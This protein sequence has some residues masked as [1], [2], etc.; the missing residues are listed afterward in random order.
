MRCWESTA[1]IWNCNSWAKLE[2]G[3]AAWERGKASQILFLIFSQLMKECWDLHTLDTPHAFGY[4]THLWVSLLPN[5]TVPSQETLMPPCCCSW[6]SPGW[7]RS[8]VQIPKTLPGS[9]TQPQPWAAHGT[10]TQSHEQLLEQQTAK[11]QGTIP[12]FILS[13]S[14]LAQSHGNQWDKAHVQPHRLSPTVCWVIFA[15]F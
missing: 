3:A 1:L 10:E 2:A 13:F 14:K 5:P 9:W 8:G 4:Q 6:D 7:S 11:G 12:E 15:N